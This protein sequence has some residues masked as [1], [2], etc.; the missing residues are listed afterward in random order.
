MVVLDLVFLTADLHLNHENIIKEEFGPHRRTQFSSIR[1]MNDTIIRN[2]KNKIS[3][4]DTVYVLG[5]FALGNPEGAVELISNLPGKKYLLMGNH[6][7][8]KIQ[9]G[10]KCVT[11]PIDLEHFKYPMDLFEEV[12]PES[13][14]VELEYDKYTFVMNHFPPNIS[15]ETTFPKHHIYLHA[16]SHSPQTYNMANM[17]LHIP[18]YD[19]GVDA[20]GFSPI[21]VDELYERMLLWTKKDQV[22][23]DACGALM[24]VRYSSYGSFLGCSNYPSCGRKYTPIKID[25]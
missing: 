19:V 23:C 18:V 20:N 22:K 8:P 1:E 6:D 17:A 15:P 12:Y 11:A 2:W 4:S 3:D 21:S 10:K 7:V 24:K 14:K 25:W 16:H 5:D 13:K 9:K